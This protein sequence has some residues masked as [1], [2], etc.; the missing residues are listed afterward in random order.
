MLLYS[1]SFG[2]AKEP[3]LSPWIYQKPTI[4]LKTITEEK[5]NPTCQTG[6]WRYHTQKTFGNI[7]T[8]KEFGRYGHYH[9]L[10]TNSICCPML[11]VGGFI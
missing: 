11:L 5:N 1:T 3:T 6:S 7:V 10:Q 4:E 9:N 2:Y 8:I